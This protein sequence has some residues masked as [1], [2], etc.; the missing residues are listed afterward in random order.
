MTV[1]NGLYSERSVLCYM[2]CLTQITMTTKPSIMCYL[3]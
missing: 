1:K 2:G 3:T